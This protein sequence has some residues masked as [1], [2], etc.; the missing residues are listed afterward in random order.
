M[1]EILGVS[2]MVSSRMAKSTYNSGVEVSSTAAA[3][4]QGIFPQFDDLGNAQSAPKYG[5][6]SD[7]GNK[8]ESATIALAAVNDTWDIRFDWE[9]DWATISD[10]MV[11]R[12]GDAVP[13]E[14]TVRVKSAG[15]YVESQNFTNDIEVGI[16][17]G[18]ADGVRKQMRVLIT[19]EPAWN[20][21]LYS[22]DATLPLDDDTG[23]TSV[24]SDTSETNPSSDA[25]PTTQV[26][27]GYDEGL[28]SNRQTFEGTIR[29][30]FFEAVTAGGGTV[31]S[32]WTV[33]GATDVTGEDDTSFTDED[34]YTWIFRIDGSSN[35]VLV[36][37]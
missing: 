3:T 16:L 2:I 18:L 11:F 5:W 34:T 15:V 31:T 24:G 25:P 29:E 4:F 30:V 35:T 6:Q 12:S 32:H 23:W 10:M 13:D 22:R 7:G 9:G 19:W 33:V 27:W 17:H 37:T 1:P 26:G 36:R 28:G 21:V 8:L 20:I 14:L